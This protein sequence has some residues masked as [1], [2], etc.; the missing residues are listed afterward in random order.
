[1]KFFVR[2]TNDRGDTIVEV[3]IVLA[4][5]S[6]A[7]TFSYATANK[8]LGQSRNAQEHSQALSILNSQVEYLR[9]AITK[10]TD[11]YPTR[12][13]CMNG[14]TPTADTAFGATYSSVPASSANDDFN[15]YP[16]ACKSGAFYNISVVYNP[17]PSGQPQN[18]YYTLRVRWEGA[19]GTLGRQ[20]ES[21]TYRM[22]PL[23]NDVNAGT[24]N[25]GVGSGSAGVGTGDLSTGTQLSST[26]PTMQVNVKK[27]A[28]LTDIRAPRTPDCSA[29]AN[30]DKSGTNVRLTGGSYSATD[31]TNASS[32][33]FFANLTDYQVYNAT[34]LSVPAGYE[35]CPAANPSAQAMPGT[36]S[37]IRL[38]IR[39]IC[40][41]RSTRDFLGNYGDSLGVYQDYLGTYSDYLGYYG[42]PSTI[43]WYEH[44]GLDGR[45]PEWNT[46][47]YP[48]S[49]KPNNFYQIE[50]GISVN[51]VR[52]GS[53]YYA[54]GPYYARWEQRFGTVYGAPYDHYSAPYDHY[55][56]PYEHF[57]APYDH[58][59]PD[60]TVY[61]CPA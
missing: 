59:S 5:I 7:L 23:I 57:G 34:I 61:D 47:A 39:P 6:L 51:Y 1:M 41:P 38:K 24:G 43:N 28:P 33:A 32:N 13:F 36:M 46:T 29:A 20:E 14:L 15:A 11:V 56:A 50:N 8:G 12:P 53:L 2:P 55:S 22:Q 35:A 40:T 19:G 3:L 37:T 25:N 17:G 30:L 9:S 18:S 44:T 54:T 27:I 21:L 58:Y 45:H 52:Y 4:I 10:R 26:A 42:D 48:Y 16:T 49:T 60:Y 31:T